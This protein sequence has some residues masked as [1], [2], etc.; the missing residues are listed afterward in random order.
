MIR[1]FLRDLGAA[2][3]EAILAAVLQDWE[4]FTRYAV[5]YFGGYKPPKYPS[6]RY[7]VSRDNISAAMNWP[8]ELESQKGEFFH[9]C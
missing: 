5:D 6:I 7:L 9:G 8:Q 2:E 4:G 3:A 1:R